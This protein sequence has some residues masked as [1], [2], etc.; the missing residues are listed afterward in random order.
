MGSDNATAVAK[1]VDGR[2]EARI[3]DLREQVEGL[4]KRQDG[5]V[6]AAREEGS[7]EAAK[8][9][10]E[11]TRAV[12]EA[13]A[14]VKKAAAEPTPEKEAEAGEKVEEAEKSVDKTERDLAKRVGD[15]EETL[16]PWRKG[17]K[18][19]ERKPSRF[20]PLEQDIVTL[21]GQMDQSV[22]ASAEALAIARSGVGRGPALWIVGAV[23]LAVAFVIAVILAIFTPL[24]IFWDAVWLAVGTA[25]FVTVVTWALEDLVPAGRD[26]FAQGWASA[27]SQRPRY[28]D[29]IVPGPW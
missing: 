10:N 25:A 6:S 9:A 15:V 7:A 5:N 20:D 3:G 12:K 26:G 1:F 19:G 29:D 8:T 24:T 27:R 18:L 11:G 4:V 21:R 2:L 22:S 13:E 14:A 28:S 17:E 23:S 16:A